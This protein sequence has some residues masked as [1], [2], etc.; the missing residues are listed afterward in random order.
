MALHTTTGRWRL[1]IALAFSTALLWGVGPI[2]L[3]SVLRELDP[4]TISWYRFAF[5]AAILSL[6][7][8][9]RHGRPRP[10]NLSRGTVVLLI[11]ALA[12]LSGNY[13]LFMLGLDNV[14]PGAAAVVIQTAPLFMLLGGIVVFKES[15]SRRQLLGLLLVITGLVLFFNQRFDELVSGLGRYTSGVL[16]VLLAGLIWAVYALAQKQLL[17]TLPSETIMLVVYT[18]A[19]LILLPLSRPGD[20]TDLSAINVG[21]LIFCGLN[22]LI[23]YGT[24]SESLNHIEA[25]RVSTVLATIPLMTLGMMRLVEAFAPGFI[26]AEPLNALAIIGAALV[27]AGSMLSSLSGTT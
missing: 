4:Y 7:V 6:I 15:Y 14:T 19:M 18:G 23:A 21:L 2:A 8:L 13:I 3:K 11:V 5:S 16:M 26:I 12:A 9:P 1:G 27:V 22:T 20:V 17:R 24:F 10:G 25:S